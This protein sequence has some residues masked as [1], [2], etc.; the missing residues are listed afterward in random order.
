MACTKLLKMS[1]FLKFYPVSSDFITVITTNNY[2]KLTLGVLTISK[3]GYLLDK[4]FFVLLH[5]NNF[6]KQR[7]FYKPI[8]TCKR[9]SYTLS[10]YFG[11]ARF[12]V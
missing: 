6:A 5:D 3:C 1:T 9:I 10:P 4:M 2:R 12:S 8:C 11:V 7:I